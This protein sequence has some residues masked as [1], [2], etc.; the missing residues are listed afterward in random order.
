MPWSSCCITLCS[1]MRMNFRCTKHSNIQITNDKSQPR[2]VPP[3]ISPLWSSMTSPSIPISGFKTLI[4]NSKIS[5]KP[6]PSFPKISHLKTKLQEFKCSKKSFRPKYKPPNSRLKIF[7]KKFSIKPITGS[8]DKTSW[9]SK[10]QSS[11]Y[12]NL[13]QVTLST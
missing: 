8:V 3:K 4:G 1:C 5:S 11:T 10:N 6:Y 12:R 7:S 2:S 9:D 13:H